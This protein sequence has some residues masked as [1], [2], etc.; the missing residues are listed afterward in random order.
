M[1]ECEN[2]KMLPIAR[3]RS[4]WFWLLVLATLATLATFA[5][6]CVIGHAKFEGEDMHLYPQ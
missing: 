5:S 3:P 6:G 4:N 2:V 1:N